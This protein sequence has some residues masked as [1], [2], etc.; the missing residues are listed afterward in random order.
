MSPP[1]LYYPTLKRYFHQVRTITVASKDPSSVPL[2]LPLQDDAVWN[3]IV[4]VKAF[5]MSTNVVFLKVLWMGGKIDTKNKCLF[6]Y[7]Q[8]LPFPMEADQYN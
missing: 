1:K 3:T 8:K 6:E 4:V 7:K 5:S 2:K